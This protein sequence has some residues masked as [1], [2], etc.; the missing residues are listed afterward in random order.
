MK[1]GRTLTELAAEVERQSATKRDYLA[2]TRKLAIAFS[3]SDNS[4]VLDGVNGGM[5]LRPIAHQQLANAL[6]I[7]KPYYDRMMET[8]PDLLAQ[9]ANHWLH[10]GSA[11]RLIRTLDGSV[12]AI[13][14][15][16]YRP[17]D[18]LDLAT[19]VLP[20][21]TR[22]GA[23][24]V[25]GEVTESRFY[26][27]ATTER[28]QG[29]VTVGDVVQAGVVVSNSEVGQGSLRVEEMNYRLVCFNGMIIAT[30]VRKAHLGRNGGRG[31]D[32]IEDAR[33]FFKD[34]TR[35]AD[36]KAFFLKVRDAVGA[37]FD[38]ARFARRIETLQQAS[39]DRPI[40]ADPEAVVE[41]AAKRFGLA[42][43]ERKGVFAELLRGNQMSA[44]GLANAITR[45]S[46]DVES[47]DRCTELEALG[48]KV[49]ELSATDWRTL[50]V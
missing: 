27:K 31:Q 26:L 28:I 45:Y 37:M 48:G 1:A 30:A 20:E 16:S 32:A 21:L 18:N 8:A 34:A 29:A 24:V 4:V 13:L 6:Q 46:Q 49:I 2:D 15:D 10:A 14:S 23:Q 5:P 47:Y 44:Y 7:P 41:L 9:N 25:S 11:K 42:E 43:G 35:Q 39:S 33:E 12:R 40:T 19:A 50:A 3:P 38:P 22:I 17:L 36:D